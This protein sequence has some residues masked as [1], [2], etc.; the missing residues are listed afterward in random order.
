MKIEHCQA[1]LVDKNMKCPRDVEAECL[2][3]SRRFF[4]MN[5]QVPMITNVQITNAQCH[6]YQGCTAPLCFMDKSLAQACWYPGEP[7]CKL[8]QVPKWVKKQRRIAKALGIAKDAD[9]GIEDYGAFTVKMLEVIRAVSSKIKGINFETETEQAWL[10]KR[11][12]LSVSGGIID[13]TKT[14]DTP[15]LPFA[16]SNPNTGLN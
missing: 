10:N 16:P 13:M 15:G 9:K 8:R 14:L 2:I 12:V 1:C 11:R 5:Q 4:R 7:V 6:G 3:C